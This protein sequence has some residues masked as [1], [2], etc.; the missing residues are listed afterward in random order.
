MSAMAFADIAE[1]LVERVAPDGAIVIGNSV[2]G[3]SAARLAV[4]RPELVR[5]L[6][7]IDGGGFVGRPPHVRALCALMAR[8]GFLRRIYPAFSASY[9]RARTDADRRARD[10]GVATTRADPGLTVVAELWRSFASPEHDLREQAGAIRAP[11]LVLW[12]RRDPVISLR[13]GR[14]IAASIPGA[15]LVEFDSGHVPQTTDPDGVAS[16]LLAF[17][18]AVAAE[19]REEQAPPLERLATP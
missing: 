16:E 13:I 6:V 15:R 10:T 18:A 14:R 8:P 2:G 12:G 11:T 4:R 3:F 17:A 19:A 1:A 5:G 9:M 7:I